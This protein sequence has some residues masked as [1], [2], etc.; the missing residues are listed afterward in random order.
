MMAD[1][2]AR[3]DARVSAPGPAPSPRVV[4]LL[5]VELDPVDSAQALA[6]IEALAAAGGCHQVVTVNPELVIHAWRDPT[7]RAVLNQ[8]ALRLA[9]GVGLLWAARLLGQHL[10]ERVTGVDTFE[11][12][13]QR[14]A[15]VGWRVFLLGGAPGVAELA[16]ERLRARAPGLR[17]AGTYAGSPSPADEADILRRIRAAAPDVL[18]VAFGS[19]AQERWIA[20]HRDHLAVP[21]AMGVGGAFD[22][23]AGRVARA[24]HWVQRAG[25]EWLFRLARQPWRWRRQ[26]A[27][28]LFVA[29][30]LRAR[31][32]TGGAEAGRVG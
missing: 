3:T 26:L 16:A 14:C 19:P 32:K 20:R 11:R 21:I 17:V 25:L 27:L 7:Y 31:L 10:P 29:L 28:P 13:A 9:D 12:L 24:P 6:R 8:A 4:R 5:G 18:F 1:G 22:F 23:V 15:A 30:V 2:A